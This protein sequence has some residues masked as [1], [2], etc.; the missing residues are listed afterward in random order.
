MGDSQFLEWQYKTRA[1][2][3]SPARVL[4]G[5]NNFSFVAWRWQIKEIGRAHV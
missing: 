1:G 4:L 3:T 5:I 2:E